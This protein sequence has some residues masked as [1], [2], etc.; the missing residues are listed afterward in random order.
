MS[1]VHSWI[2]FVLIVIAIAVF[3]ALSYRKR[4]VLHPSQLSSSFTTR[5]KFMIRNAGHVITNA[6]NTTKPTWNRTAA[7]DGIIVFI[8]D[9]VASGEAGRWAGNT[10]KNPS[11]IDASGKETY[12]DND[13]RSGERITGCHRS[14]VIELH[15]EVESVNLACSG[16]ETVS[17]WYNNDKGEFFK[18]GLDFYKD[19]GHKGHAQLL[20]DIASEKSVKVVLVSIGANDYKL[21]RVV[22]RCV[23]GFV[24]SF[25]ANK[26]YCHDDPS[27]IEYFSKQK[28]NQIT[29]SI[30]EGLTNIF[31]AMI[32]AGYAL[33]QWTLLIQTYPKVLPG[34][35]EIRHAELGFGRQVNGGCGFYDA[36]LDWLNEVVLPIINRSVLRAAARITTAIPTANIRILQTEDML[37]GRRVC[38]T[39]VGTLEDT[40]LKSWKDDHAVDKTEWVSKINDKPPYHKSESLHPNHWAQLGLRNCVRQAYNMGGIPKGGNC[41]RFGDGLTEKGEPDMMLY[42]PYLPNDEKEK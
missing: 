21:G 19:R 34:S 26:D 1:S 23:R 8:G 3:I 25:S 5:E 11:S 27:T 38:E 17:A 42:P 37:V 36:D 10:H 15:G 4:A 35:D 32:K 16:A 28:V 29:K 13:D 24:S 7:D 22:E 30:F 2:M 39:G 9:S 40:G 31:L 6:V 20:L 18:P 12:F 14:H 41:K 33:N